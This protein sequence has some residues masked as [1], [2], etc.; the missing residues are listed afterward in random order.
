MRAEADVHVAVMVELAVEER[1]ADMVGGALE[2]F[3]VAPLQP[4]CAD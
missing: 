2:A 4:R 3:R 1:A